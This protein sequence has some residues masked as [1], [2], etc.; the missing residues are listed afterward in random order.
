[1]LE[2]AK[3]NWSNAGS[4]INRFEYIF[5]YKRRVEFKRAIK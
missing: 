4:T 5:M 1:M 2:T 3:K